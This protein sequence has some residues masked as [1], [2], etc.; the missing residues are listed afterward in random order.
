M[1][2]TLI[3]FHIHNKK[4]CCGSDNIWRKFSSETVLG[5]NP[6]PLML[7]VGSSEAEKIMTTG[8]KAYSIPITTRANR[9]TC[10][11]VRCGSTCALRVRATRT[12]FTT[13]TLVV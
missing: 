2:E 5:N 8:N 7:L 12:V 1:P 10:F 4:G 11:R 3:E 6:D 9:K 13:G